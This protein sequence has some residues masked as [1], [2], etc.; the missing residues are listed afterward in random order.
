MINQDDAGLSLSRDNHADGESTTDAATAPAN[1]IDYGLIDAVVDETLSRNPAP[2][3]NPFDERPI[4][5][6]DPLQGTVRA[7]PPPSHRLR[8]LDM[9]ACSADRLCDALTRMHV[10]DRLSIIVEY[11]KP[12]ISEQRPATL[13][14]APPALRA[15]RTADGIVELLKLLA[16]NARGQLANLGAP[17]LAPAPPRHMQRLAPADDI[18]A[19]L[20]TIA[21]RY[22]DQPDIWHRLADIAFTCGSNR[23]GEIEHPTFYQTTQ[24]HIQARRW[25]DHVM[26]H[27]RKIRFDHSISLLASLPASHPLARPDAEDIPEHPFTAARRLCTLA[28]L[29]LAIGDRGNRDRHGALAVTMIARSK[30]IGRRDLFDPAIFA[31]TSCA[32]IWIANSTRRMDGRQPKSGTFSRFVEEFLAE[33]APIFPHAQL[34]TALRMF[35]DHRDI[36]IGAIAGKLGKDPALFLPAKPRQRRSPG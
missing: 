34:R 27:L 29:V 12:S 35:H 6:L 25:A 10:A 1:F 24:T 26:Q 5:A 21:V 32:S 15:L 22:F 13:L 28:R 23:V 14:G 30:G 18:Q 20:T 9:L 7:F 2:A 16:A 11:N 4:S 33:A 8:N 19:R 36:E 3:F 17:D 31:V